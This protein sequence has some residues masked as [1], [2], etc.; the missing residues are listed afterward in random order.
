MYLKF[1][2]FPRGRPVLS[3]AEL[4]VWLETIEG[5]R[6]LLNALDRQ[7]RRDAGMSHDDYE[8]L[9]RLYR[10]PKRMMRMSDLASDVGSSPS[11]LSHAMARLEDEGL[12][13]RARCATD[14][15]GVNGTLTEDGAARIHEASTGHLDY[16]RRL[17]FD[18]LGSDRAKELG[19]ALNEI[20]R[21]ALG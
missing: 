9:G 5:T 13:R 20:R 17:V 15:R 16:V 19:D 2:L 11:R 6:A 4:R 21:A 7:L 1:Q 10:A 14:G 18:T 12:V 8:I 3:K